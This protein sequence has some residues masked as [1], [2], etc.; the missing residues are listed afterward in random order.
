MHKTEV[1]TPG[2]VLWQRRCNGWGPL[3]KRS[4]LHCQMVSSWSRSRA[5]SAARRRGAA[6]M[7]CLQSCGE[8]G[9][10][11]LPTLCTPKPRQSLHCR[12]AQDFVDREQV[13]LPNNFPDC[14][15]VG[16]NLGVFALVQPTNKHCSTAQ[17]EDW[18]DDDAQTDHSSW[19]IR[20]LQSNCQPAAA[21]VHFADEPLHH[22]HKCSRAVAHEEGIDHSCE[23]AC[24]GC[25]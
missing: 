3:A 1:Q 13:Q 16:H 20:C 17:C 24:V 22:L 23:V 21:R 6:S 10:A 9:P 8:V 25:R 4:S 14:A 2:Q 11:Q 18:G 7:V 5:S 12:C 15:A 19:H